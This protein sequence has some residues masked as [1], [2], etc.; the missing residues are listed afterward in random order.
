MDKE[1]KI[2]RN[3]IDSELPELSRRVFALRG[4]HYYGCGFSWGREKRL[5]S[6]MREIFNYDRIVT[7]I[8]QILIET[9]YEE[10]VED[11]NY[12]EKEVGWREW[13][14]KA[15]VKESG[16][17]FKSGKKIGTPIHMTIHHKLNIPAFEMD[18][19]SI[20]ECRRCKLLN[21]NKAI[22]LDKNDNKIDL[23]RK[24]K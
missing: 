4:K 24:D 18:D 11:L 23:N 21:D 22:R 9:L 19:G 7:Q 2:L 12:V 14:H 20:I 8:D 5:G 17:P 6:L 13:L 3:K 10:L 1:F 16:K 15:I